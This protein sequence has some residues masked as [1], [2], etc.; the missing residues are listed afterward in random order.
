MVQSLKPAQASD[1]QAYKGW[2]SDEQPVFE[3]ETKFLDHG[4][5]LLVFPRD[6]VGLGRL[7]WVVRTMVAEHASLAVTM[8]ML[9]F[10]LWYALLP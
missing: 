9:M 6:G 10:A 5:D 3:A 1:I 8:F 4:D 2:L 7:P